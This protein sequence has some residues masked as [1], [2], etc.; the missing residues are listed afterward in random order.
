VIWSRIDHHMSEMTSGRT[1]SGAA[2]FSYGF[3]PFFFTAALFAGVAIPAWITVLVVTADAGLLASARQW[4]MHEMVFGF[5]PAVITGFVLTAIPNWTDRPPIRGRELT[6]LWSLWLAGRLVMAGSWFPAV[7]SSLVDAAFLI[8]VAGIIWHEITRAQSW[9]QAP[10]GGLISLYAAA[11]IGYHALI[12]SGV[13]ADAAIRGGLAVTMVLL[14]LIGGRVTP[15]FTSEFLS[16]RR[17]TVQPAPLSG[18]DGLSVVTV[19]TAGL[20]WIVQPEGAVTGA[21]FVAAGSL[22]V[23]RVSRWRGWL[24]WKEPLVL[25]LHMGYGWLALSLLLLGSAILGF[26]LPVTDA[27]H[28]L[29]AGAVGAMTLAVMTR[30]SL[31]HTGRQRHAAGPT[32]L[33][34]LL[35]NL[36]AIL[37]VVGVSTGLPESVVLAVAAACWSGAYLMFAWIYGPYLF[38]IGLDD[39]ST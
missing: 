6:L 2:F 27:L 10:I 19:A 18:L 21:V 30:A 34:Y 37:R 25:I 24:T 9:R 16:D 14:A 17:R 7:F 11:H 5:L 35:V 15:A 3:R 32:V 22:N 33:L 26:G 29:T 28:A 4:H 1:G 23:G 13:P 36:G 8:V 31:G 12:L 39:E 20:L 38:T